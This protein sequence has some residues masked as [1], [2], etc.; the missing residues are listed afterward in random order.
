M[1]VAGG[2]FNSPQ[3]LQLS[4]I[5]PAEVLEPLGIPVRVNLPGV[6]RNLQ[7]RY[8]VGIVTELDRSFKLLARGAFRPPQPGDPLDPALAE[9]RRGKGPYK[10]NGAVLAAMVKSKPDLPVPDLFLFALPANFR[11]YF[12]GYAKTLQLTPNKLTWA[13]LKAHT[14]NKAGTVTVRSTDPRDVPEIAFR[15][16]EEGSDPSGADLAAMVAGVRFVRGVNERLGR[17]ATEMS[18]GPD[19]ST[20]E[21]IQ[22]WVR[23]NA[24]GHHACGTCAV[25]PDGDPGAVLDSRFR[26]RGVPGLRVVDA[27]VFPTIPGYFL[28][29]SVFMI[30]EKAADVILEDAAAPL[31]AW[32]SAPVAAVSVTEA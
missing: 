21:E 2:A 29:S 24:W 15:Y 3:I 28:V 17:R 5:G 25:G 12:P 27:S 6:G 22:G 10:T 13:V 26:V 7:D 31:T 14:N 20:T 11:G 23:D 16:F 32:P 19:I 4:G 18:P 9:W 30:G 8:E 1:I